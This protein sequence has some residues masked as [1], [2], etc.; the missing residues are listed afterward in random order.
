MK[1]GLSLLLLI[2]SIH[3]QAQTIPEAVQGNWF[4]NDGTNTWVI[5]LH[6]DYVVFDSEFW[7][8]TEL[9]AEDEGL[10]LLLKQPDDEQKITLKQAGEAL[11]LTVGGEVSTL[12]AERIKPDGKPVPAGFSGDFIKPGQVELAGVLLAKGEMP[13]VA[14]VIFNDAFTEG[15][16]KFT[17]NVDEYGRFNVSFPLNS[18]QSVM[19]SVGDA[20]T[21]FLAVPDSKMAIWIDESSFLEGFDSWYNAEEMLYM[22]DM[23]Q[24]NEEYR[25]YNPEYMKVRKYFENDSLQQSLE[26]MDYLKYR[27]EL[28]ESHEAFNQKYF[29]ENVV[30]EKVKQYVE[31]DVRLY[32]ANDLMRYRWMHNLR[33]SRITM[34]LPDEY[35]AKVKSMITA[36]PKELMS[37]EY[38]D[39]MREI[40]MRM[41][42]REREADHVRRIAKVY[43]FLK[44]KALSETNQQLLEYWKG[45]ETNREKH[46]GFVKFPD[47][48]KSFTDPYTAEL[49]DLNDRLTWQIF[50]E[51]ISD[52][53]PLALSS[54]INNYID[55][56]YF[57]R[58]VEVPDFIWEDIQQLALIPMAKALLETR[59]KDMAILMNEKFVDGVELT[60][61]ESDIL[62]QLKTKYAGKVVYIDVWATWCGPCISEFSHLPGIKTALADREDIVFVY[63]CAQSK[64]KGWQTMVK[65]HKLQGDNLY[66]SDEQYALFD[67]ETNVTGFPTYMVIT[68]EGKLVRN[69]I[70]RPSAGEG[71]TEQLI[72][73]AERQ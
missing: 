42:P 66:L 58:G 26:P 60:N 34:D 70:K 56:A 19:L 50:K 69:G 54:I 18:P 32:A 20:F 71:L 33:S 1:T 35:V 25:L 41:M 4:A 29:A 65:K 30:S 63:L 15:Q 55:R 45:W 5:G 59:K 27:V 72:E 23:A 68:K 16:P 2:L 36:D 44:S 3:L 61:S 10:T 12:V 64:E 52:Y 46:F 13:L 21:T 51:S 49:A 67:K 37:G 73:F 53:G 11:E 9:K 7:E 57:S 28:M 31:R 38:G 40:S 6:K 22:G 47:T 39:L 8:Y 17:V 43:D 24:E 62:N 48:L 14:S